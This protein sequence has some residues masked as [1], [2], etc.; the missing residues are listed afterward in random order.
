MSGIIYA[1][2]E[3]VTGNG[4][5]QT[6]AVQAVINKAINIVAPQ[7]GQSVEIVWP[8]GTILLSA[9]ITCQS[10]NVNMS[11]TGQGRR[12]TRFVRAS[13]YGDTFRFT[14]MPQGTFADFG[15]ESTTEMNQGAHIV[16]DSLYQCVFR[17]IYL[18]EGYRSL[19]L[20]NCA[21]CDF[22]GIKAVGGDK[23]ASVPANGY[24]AGAYHV[25]LE[26][27]GA[28][29]NSLTF[30]RCSFDPSS[31]TPAQHS[32]YEA[33]FFI[34]SVDGLLVEGG[35]IAGGKIA[36]ILFDRAAGAPLSAVKFEGT[37]VDFYADT[38]VQIQGSLAT[39]DVQFNGC[40]FQGGRQR[41]VLIANAEASGIHFNDVVNQFSEGEAMYVVSGRNIVVNGGHIWGNNSGAN[42]GNTLVFTGPQTR[43]VILNAPR[44]EGNGVT[45]NV[46][47]SGG[48]SGAMYS[49]IY[50]GAVQNVYN[51]GNTNVVAGT[52]V[53]V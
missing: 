52:V 44:V 43:N 47:F 46:Q 10:G 42:K 14:T 16:G 40:T 31:L 39:I 19:Q 29:N 15:I 7:N 13:D 28:G 1:D 27:G 51:V 6:A 23:F 8:V 18:A 20:R 49:G 3:G 36:H 35:H 41:N 21:N 48:M 45:Y 37:H 24:K 4:T 12:V 53:L 11:W 26:P 2:Q 34:R 33:S 22:V 32:N 9:T 5:D 30:V 17:D 50:S 38:T 25:F